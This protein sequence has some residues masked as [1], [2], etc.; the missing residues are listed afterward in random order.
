MLS[1]ISSAIHPSLCFARSENGVGSNHNQ[2]DKFL[3]Q[4][5]VSINKLLPC[6]LS[7]VDA[8]SFE[9]KQFVVCC[10]ISPKGNVFPSLYH[11][12]RRRRVPRHANAITD[13]LMHGLTSKACLVTFQPAARSNHSRNIYDRC[14]LT[15]HQAPITTGKERRHA[16]TTHRP[17]S[18]ACKRYRS[19]TARVSPCHAVLA[20]ITATPRPC[21]SPTRQSF[22]PPSA[23]ALVTLS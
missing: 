20:K 4:T 2:D 8:L 23:S 10:V 11:A 14:T 22:L 19:R 18:P 3:Y 12:C 7:G 16:V 15:H 9:R 5:Y 21:S 1:S 17:S 6:K 13:A